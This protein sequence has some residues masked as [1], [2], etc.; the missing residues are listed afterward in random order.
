MCLDAHAHG[1]RIQ[2]PIFRTPNRVDLTLENRPTPDVYRNAGSGFEKTMP[3]WRVQTEGYLDGTDQLVGIVSRD[4][5]FLD[6][7]DTE[8]IS[9]GVNTKGPNAVAIGRHG[10][11][12]HWGFAAS[13]TYMTE[14]AQLVFIN[15][16]HYI[17]QFD[18]RP[19]IT[20]K[21]SRQMMR[22]YVEDAIESI[23]PEGYQ[24]R[25]DSHESLLESMKERQANLQAKK[26]AGEA[27]EEWEE[28]MLASPPQYPAPEMFERVRRVA[29]L[30]DR[31]RAARLY[32]RGALYPP[33]RWPAAGHPQGEPADDAQ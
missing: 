22:S 23:T 3:M 9:G 33:V 1:M 31:R 27:M 12:F 8:W 13:P 15:A 29:D 4:R 5:G 26:D 24:R 20:R 14:D 21:V 2:H 7:P 6:S 11:F 32:Q 17:H 25:L 16:V 18:G 10:N 28:Q 30:H 19:P